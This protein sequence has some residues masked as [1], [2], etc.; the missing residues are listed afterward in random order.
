LNSQV[1][2]LRQAL[3]KESK[4]TTQ[5]KTALESKKRVIKTLEENSLEANSDL[6]EKIKSH[7]EDII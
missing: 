6:E 7:E 2:S 5:L 4:L 1:G 3:K